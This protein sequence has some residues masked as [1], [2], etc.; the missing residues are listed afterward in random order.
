LIV[1]C[2]VVKQ[3]SLVWFGMG[4]IWFVTCRG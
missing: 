2:H 3:Q 1:L 4:M